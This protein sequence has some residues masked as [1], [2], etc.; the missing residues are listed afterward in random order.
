LIVTSPLVRAK[1]TAQILARGLR[2]RP[3]L[4]TSAAL[5]PEQSPAKAAASLRDYRKARQIA[6]VGH[7]PGLGELAA[8]L[9]G[10]DTPLA[11]KKG[12]ICRL[13]VPAVPGAGSAQLIWFAT[14]RL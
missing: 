12:G 13:E 4:K 11:F 8:W 7:E 1:Q 14:P 2:P 9:L 10:A 5:A 6:L 3:P